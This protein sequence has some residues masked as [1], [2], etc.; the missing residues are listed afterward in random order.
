MPPRT[1]PLAVLLAGAALLA[2][3]GGS[4]EPESSAPAPPTSAPAR[5][6]APAPPARLPA[7]PQ[8][9]AT[10]LDVPWGLAFLPNGDALVSERSSGRILRV[11][12]GGGAPRPVMTV[13]GVD[14]AAGEGGLLGL[15]VSPA[16]ARDGLV[17]AYLTTADDN[18]IVRFRLGGEPEP[19]L[20]GIARGGIHNGGRI[21][22]GPDGMLYAGAGDAGDTSLPQDPAS[23]NGKIL[24]IAPDGSVPA[25]NPDAGSPV[26]SSGHRNVQGLAW[27]SGGR[28][29]A[30]EF[31]QNALDE[32]NLIEPGANY[33]WPEVEGEGGGAEFT[34]PQVTWPTSEASPSGAAIVGGDLYVA[35]L[36]GERLWRVPLRGARAGAPVAALEGELGRLRTVAVAPDGSLWLATSNTDG[37]GSPRPGDDRIV[38]MAPPGTD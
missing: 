4:D 14:P 32:V 7:T 5:T 9:V 23:P 38:R 16:Y 25:D 37:R 17:Y 8:D 19:L 2:G 20:T 31:G 36:R 24:R 13:P 29:W 1:V 22:F 11:P 28:L 18:R 12:A 33:G 27:D 26:W 35:A 30:T 21:A 34:D 3:C 15:A 6:T 10:G